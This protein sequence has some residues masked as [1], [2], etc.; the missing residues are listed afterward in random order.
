MVI[1]SGSAAVCCGSEP[2]A[3]SDCGEVS[4]DCIGVLGEVLV[5]CTGALADGFCGFTKFSVVVGGVA[6]SLIRMRFRA[7][8]YQFGMVFAEALEGAFDR[9]GGA[10]GQLVGGGWAHGE[11]F[12]GA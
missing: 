11:V 9:G 4:G 8:L 10:G 6:L 1:A 2:G 5:G 3:V 7:R 12:E